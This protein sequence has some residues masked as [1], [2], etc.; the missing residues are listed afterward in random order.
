[1]GKMMVGVVLLLL[2]L[3][4]SQDMVLWQAEAALC[5]SESK[6]FHGPCFND[7]NCGQI[8]E[9][10][11]FLSGKCDWTKCICYKDCGGGGR[12]GGGGGSG[13]GPCP[14]PP[15]PTPP[16]PK[17][18]CPKPPSP[19]PTPPSPKPPCGPPSAK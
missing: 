16:S 12:G 5:K 18:P 10:E 4:I 11:G 8:C 9:S 2:H 3:L 13:G 17:P 15:C 7:K 6:K 19:C 1:M 14:K